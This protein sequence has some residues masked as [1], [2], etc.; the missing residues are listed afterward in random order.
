MKEA[1]MYAA[2]AHHED[3]G[4]LITGGQNGW[5]NRHSSTEIT[6]DGVTFEDFTPLPRA[7][8]YHCMVALNDPADGD[9]F[10]AGGYPTSKRAFIHKGNQWDEMAE[11]PTARYRKKPSLEIENELICLKHFIAGLMCGPVRAS[12]GGRVEKIV[13]AG[14]RDI[15]SYLDKV[16]IYD[17]TGNTWTK[18]GLSGVVKKSTCI[19]AV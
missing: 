15:G 2:A 19:A 1:R 18:G 10:V 7:L 4:F 17:I 5:N 11:M 14:G 13:A 6:K 16:E 8:S 9:F 3:K 12:P